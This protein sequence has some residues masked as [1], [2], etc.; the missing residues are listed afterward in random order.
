MIN[1]AQTLVP[2]LGQLR[3]ALRDN[4]MPPPHTE[5]AFDTQPA[6]EVRPGYLP[7]CLVVHRRTCELALAGAYDSY[8]DETPIE[9]LP[10]GVD[11]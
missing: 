11:G 9:A 4:G 1:Q 5:F 8:P 6:S 10:V 2:T 7:D 3:K